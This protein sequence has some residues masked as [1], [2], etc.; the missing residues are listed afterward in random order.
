MADKAPVFNSSLL[1]Q[2]VQ[3]ENQ[4]LR[5]ANAQMHRVESERQTRATQYLQELLS[6]TTDKGMSVE[7]TERLVQLLLGDDEDGNDNDNDNDN[8]GGMAADA[9]EIGAENA[10]DPESFGIGGM[11]RHRLDW[12]IEALRELADKGTVRGAGEMIESA[13]AEGSGFEVD[14]ESRFVVFT[15][16]LG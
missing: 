3:A 6:E 2:D 7:D 16:S 12:D 1:L 10:D 8:D 4:R 13:V 11:A 9:F 5:T 14:G 15:E